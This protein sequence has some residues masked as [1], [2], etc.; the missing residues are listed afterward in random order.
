MDRCRLATATE[1]AAIADKSDLDYAQAVIALPNG[2]A[3]P[4]I[5]VIKQVWELDPVIYA[6]D[7]G[8]P[9]KYMFL[10]DLETIMQFQGVRAYYFN[11][12]ANDTH[13][14]DILKKLGAE[15]LSPGPEFRFKKLL[16]R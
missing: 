14:H 15:Q 6:P 4:D 7:S 9:R 1:I 11:A 8:H 12:P 2:S 16:T 13:Y 5:G 10:R 3:T